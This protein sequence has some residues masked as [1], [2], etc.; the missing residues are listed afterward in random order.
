M[1]VINIASRIDTLEERFDRRPDPRH[2][3]EARARALEG[4]LGILAAFDRGADPRCAM[5]KALIEHELD[6]GAAIRSPVADKAA[7]RLG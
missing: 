5:S 3:E 4:I 7:A 2:A 1:T 6:I